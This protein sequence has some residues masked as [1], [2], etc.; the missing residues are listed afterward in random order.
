[1]QNIALTGAFTSV[2]ATKWSRR[3]E[4][5]EDGSVT[6]TGLLI[7]LP[8]DNFTNV[9]TYPADEQ[10]IVL[11]NTIAHGNGDGST[12]GR[13]AQTGNPPVAATELCRIASVG[14]A[15]VIRV[16]EID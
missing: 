9:Y 5:E 14:A 12:V 11:G 15:T 8:D 2:Y 13:P 10:P 4:I 1:M 3:V 7:K 6:K 16:N